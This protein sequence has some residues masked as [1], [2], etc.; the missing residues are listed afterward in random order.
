ML[1]HCFR[2][3]VMGGGAG[4]SGPGGCLSSVAANPTAGIPFPGVPVALILMQF[5]QAMHI[6]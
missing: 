2:A 1:L 4:Y 3:A 6:G 5:S